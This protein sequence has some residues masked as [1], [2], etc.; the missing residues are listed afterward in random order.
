MNPFQRLSLF[1]SYS[2]KRKLK[3]I[4][5]ID[6][7]EGMTV[8]ERLWVTDLDDEFH[9]V[10]VKDK[11][12]A[13]QILTWLKVDE[14]SINVIIEKTVKSDNIIEIG[15]DSSGRLY[16]IPEYE[17]FSMIWRSATEV[18]WDIEKRYL[19]SPKPREWSYYQWFCQIIMAVKDEYGSD[20][21]V[22]STT[23]WNRISEQLRSEIQLAN[24]PYR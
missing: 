15:I 16:I 18:H 20:L 2:D 1:N 13:R 5:S 12:R 4:S 24:F 14:L 21:V 10:L 6:G 19:Y 8:N 17:D 7:L 23:K 22:T 11:N 9:E 3:K